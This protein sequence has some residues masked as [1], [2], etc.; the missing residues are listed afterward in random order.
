MIKNLLNRDYLSQYKE[1]D[2]QEQTQILLEAINAS[3]MIEDAQLNELLRI[4]Q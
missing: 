1:V 2:P 4:K 3:A